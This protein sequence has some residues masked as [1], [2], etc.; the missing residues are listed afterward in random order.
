[1]I[2]YDSQSHQIKKDDGY[3]YQF[4]YDDKGTSG[5]AFNESLL[6][7]Y[8]HKVLYG[9]PFEI[10]RLLELRV[11]TERIGMCVPLFA[12]LN[13]VDGVDSTVLN[14]WYLFLASCFYCDVHDELQI[15]DSNDS[16]NS[17]PVNEIYFLVIERKQLSSDSIDECLWALKEK[18][19]YAYPGRRNKLLEDVGY[20]K[21]INLSLCSNYLKKSDYIKTLISKETS[22]KGGGLDTRTELFQRFLEYYQVIEL[23]LNDV[24]MSMILNNYMDISYGNSSLRGSDSDKLSELN[25]FNKIVEGLHTK[26]FSEFN[27][28]CVKLLESL[29]SSK[30][31][32]KKFPNTLYQVRNSIV[33]R[34]RAFKKSDMKLLRDILDHFELFLVLLLHEYRGSS[35]SS[36]EDNFEYCKLLAND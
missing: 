21:I 19:L 23:L 32:V 13:W 14:R 27:A 33:H 17:I 35:S 8:E 20:S 2:S 12:V 29:N 22:Y 18:G 25:R 1:M 4:L 10:C 7:G 34:M 31:L 36:I 5:L 6:N 9:Y 28:S 24:L 3:T 15:D 16:I 26:D 11:K 30:Y